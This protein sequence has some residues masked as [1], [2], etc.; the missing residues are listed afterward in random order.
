[1]KDY[2]IL[3]K[4]YPDFFAEIKYVNC[5][6]GW[7]NLIDIMCLT[8]SNHQK[9]M[10]EN[11]PNEIVDP[12]VFQQIK[13]KFGILR[14]YYKGGNEYIHGIVRMAENLSSKICEDCGNSGD[15]FVKKSG[16][17]RTLCESCSKD[18]E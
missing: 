15:K 11:W 12:V 1:M 16:W 17:L 13:E 9:A 4:K 6:T 3:S 18:M 7:Y 14:V 10:K 5:N 2:Q 8:I